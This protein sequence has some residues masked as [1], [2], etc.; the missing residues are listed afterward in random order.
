V[1]ADD[2][3]RRDALWSLALGYARTVDRGDTEG[4]LELFTPDAELSMHNPPDTEAGTVYR[5]HGDL[6]R[7]P[8]RLARFR[9]TFHLLGQADYH[10]DGDEPTGEVYCVA[11]HRSAGDDDPTDY[12]MFIRYRDRYR[13]HDDGWR[14]AERR[15]LVDWTETRPVNPP[16]R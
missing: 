4:F 15:V 10:L 7:I 16:G 14:I 3:G 12:V 13:H 11:H 1:S 9:A 5:G 2:P 8:P 6:A